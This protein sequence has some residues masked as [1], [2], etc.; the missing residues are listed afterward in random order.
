MVVT[1]L[2]AYEIF[3]KAKKLLQKKKGYH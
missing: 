1:S 3:I 2:I